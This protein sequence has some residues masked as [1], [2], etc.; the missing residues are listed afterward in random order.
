MAISVNRKMEG[1][2]ISNINTEWKGR[3]LL[4]LICLEINSREK[5]SH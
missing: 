1:D 3:R 2:Q 5:Q 4:S